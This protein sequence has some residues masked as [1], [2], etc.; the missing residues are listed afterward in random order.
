MNNESKILG[1]LLLIIF[2]FPFS[3][4]ELICPPDH[5]KIDDYYW[6]Y[7]DY[8]DEYE[9]LY[10]FQFNYRLGNIQY[11]DYWSGIIYTPNNF[12]YLSQRETRNDNYEH[13]YNEINQIEVNIGDNIDNEDDENKDKENNDNEDYENEDYDNE[14]SNEEDNN[15]KEYDDEYDEE[16]NDNED[17]ENYYYEKEDSNEENNNNKE[18]EDIITGLVSCD[19]PDYENPELIPIE[20]K[21]IN[22]IDSDESNIPSEP[23]VKIDKE[24]HNHKSLYENACPTINNRILIP[25]DEKILIGNKYVF[26]FNVVNPSDLTIKFKFQAHTIITSFSMMR[27]DK[28]KWKKYED[29]T[30]PLTNLIEIK[31]HSVLKVP[32]EI[33]FNDL[34]QYEGLPFNKGTI[35]SN[36][37]GTSNEKYYHENVLHWRKNLTNYVN[38]SY[39]IYSALEIELESNNQLYISTYS[40]MHK[41]KNKNILNYIGDNSCDSDKSCVEGYGCVSNECIKCEK[42]TCSGCLNN[43]KNCTKCFPISKNGQ[44]NVI[45]TNQNL[46]CDLNFVDITKFDI[47]FN[48]KKQVPPAI[49]FRVT[50]EFWMFVASP[51]LIKGKF[52]NI[53]YKD[54][55]VI[56]L[57]PKT[58][59]NQMNIYCIPLEFIYKFP[60]DPYLIEEVGNNFN[61]FINKTLEAPYLSETI[62]DSA[63]KWFYVRCAYNIES[64][65][66]Y[67]NDQYESNLPIPQYFKNVNNSNISQSNMPFHI[68]KFYKENDMTYL[69][70]D[71]FTNYNDT[72]IYLRNLNIYREYM[73]QNIITKYFNMHEFEYHHMFP[74]L[75]YSMPLDDVREDSININI[76][77]FNTYNYGNRDNT[78]KIEDNV[79]IISNN[80]L[81]ISSNIDNLRPPRTFQ[82]LNLNRLNFQAKD[83]DYKDYQ[84]LY[85]Y[86]NQSYCFEDYKAFACDANTANPK[87]PY[88]LDIFNFTCNEY[89]R[90]GY[91]R[92]LRDTDEIGSQYCSKSC[93]EFVKDCPFEH[94]LYAETNF[95][96]C[97]TGFFDLYYKCYDENDLMNNE[98]NV[99]MYFSG[100]LNSHTIIIPLKHEYTNYAISVWIYPEFRLRNYKY[101]LDNDK[102][103]NRPFFWDDYIDYTIFLTN[104]FRIKLGNY[105]TSCCSYYNNLEYLSGTTLRMSE[106]FNR[107]T[108]NHLTISFDQYASNYEYY[109]TYINHQYNDYMG[110][111]NVTNP[112]KLSTIIF[113]NK[114]NFNYNEYINISD[115][116]KNV[117]WYDAHYR[118][119]QIFDLSTASR[120]SAIFIDK[121]EDRPNSILKHEYFS[122]LSS[123]NRNIVKDLIGN[124]DGFIPIIERSGTFY[125]PDNSNFINYEAYYTAEQAFPDY[126]N[127]YITNVS[128]QYGSIA[129]VTFSPKDEKCIIRSSSKCLKCIKTLSNFNGNCYDYSKKNTKEAYSVYK[130]PGNNMPNKISLNIKPDILKTFPSITVFFFINIYG[131]TEEINL[132]NP[133]SKKIIIFDEATNFYLGY[134]PNINNQSLFIE[135][136][137]RKIFEY[138]NFKKDRF[139]H[140]CPISIAAFRESDRTFQLNMVQASIYLSNLPFIFTY[141]YEMP[142]LEFTELS[143]TNSW[144]GLLR[145]VKIFDDFIMN[146]LGS[147]INPN[148]D[149]TKIPFI[150]IPLRDYYND[151]ANKTDFDS[152]SDEFG[153]KCVK[154]YNP[155]DIECNDPNSLYITY[156]QG[157]AGGC[158]CCGTCG[159]NQFLLHECLGGH[160]YEYDTNSFNDQTC[161]Q[162]HENWINYYPIIDDGHFLR[163][164]EMNNFNLNRLGHI[165]VS[166]ISNIDGNW[167][168]DFWFYT[169]SFRNI[170][171]FLIPVNSLATNDANNIW[172]KNNFKNVIIEWDYHFRIKI[173]SIKLNDNPLN[174]EYK[175]YFTCTPL[176]VKNNPIYDSDESYIVQVNINSYTYQRWFYVNCGASYNEKKFYLTVRSSTLNNEKIFNPKI[177]IDPSKSSSLN[178]DENSPLGYGVTHIREL[179][180]WKCYSCSIAVK[181]TKYKTND[182]SFTNIL[183]RFRGYASRTGSIKNY[184]YSDTLNNANSIKIT[185]KSGYPGFNILDSITSYSECDE[186]DFS[187]AENEHCVNHYNIAR[188]KDFEFILPSSR[189][190]RYTLEFWFFIEQP[191]EMEN[192]LNFYW[193]KHLSISLITD[194]SNINGLIGI[195]FPQAYRDKVDGLKGNEIYDLYEKAINKDRFY[196]TEIANNWAFVRCAVDHTRKLF[197]INENL[198]LTIES[199]ILYGTTKG[200]RPFRYFD[201]SKNSNLKVQNGKINKSRI[202]LR[203]L[204]AFREYLDYKL[205]DT[206]YINFE[207]YKNSW[208]TILYADLNN[209]VNKGCYISSCFNCGY[210]NNCGLP[211]YT[212]EPD[213]SNTP[214][215]NVIGDWLKNNENVFY[216]TYPNI[217]TPIFC[218]AGKVGGINITCSG[219]TCNYCYKDTSHY[220]Y[221]PSGSYHLLDMNTLELTNDCNGNCRLPDVDP[222]TNNGYCLFKPGQNNLLSCGSTY[223]TSKSAEL[224]NNNFICS[225]GYTKVYFECIKDDIIKNSAMYFSNFFSFNNLIYV[226]PGKAEFED[227][228]YGRYTDTSLED[229]RLLSYYLE[230]WFKLD[231]INYHD[232]ISNEEIYLYGYPH[233]IFKDPKDQKFKYSNLKIA[234]GTSYHTLP[235]I[236]EYEWNRIIIENYYYKNNNTFNIKLFTN[237]QF[238]NPD[239]EILN[240]NGSLYKMHFR[241]IVFCNMPYPDCLIKNDPVYLHWGNAWY[242]NIRIWD[243]DITSLQSIQACEIGYTELMNAQKYYWPFTINYINRHEILDLINQ[244]K[245]TLNWWFWKKYYDDDIRENYSTDN[246]DYSL[247][248][249]NHYISKLIN[250]NTE[251]E[252]LPCFSTCKRCYSSSNTDCYECIQGYVLIERKCY[253]NTG[254]YFKTPPINNVNEINILTDIN[255]FHI[256]TQNPLTITIWIKYFGIQLGKTTDTGYFP[257]FYLYNKSTFLAYKPSRQ[258]L[259]F[260]I[261]NEEVEEVEA[262]VIRIKEHIGI[263]T[264]FG[265]SI[266]HSNHLINQFF[267]HMFN[268]MVNR[269][270]ISPIQFQPTNQPVYIN[271]FIF[272]TIPICYYSTLNFYSNFWYG[273]FGH[274]NGISSTRNIDLIYS[275]SLYGADPGTCI[276]DDQLNGITVSSLNPNCIPD[277]IPYDYSYNICQ[278]DKYFIDLSLTSIP[279]C[280]QCD[281]YCNE[282]FNK[283]NDKCSCDFNRGIYW[284]KSND[285]FTKY[286]C[287]KIDSINFAFYEEVTF[288]DLK[289]SNNDEMAIHFWL[290]IYEYKE[291][292]FQSIDIIWSKHIHVKIVDDNNIDP[293]EFTVNCFPYDYI[294]DPSTNPDKLSINFPYR[295]WVYIRC[296]A[297]KYYLKFRLNN[298]EENLNKI[299][300]IQD[301]KSSLTI[302][303][304]NNGNF[305]YGFSFI[306][307]L[308]LFSSY[309]FDFWDDSFIILNGNNFPYLLHYFSFTLEGNDISKIIV[310]DKIEGISQNLILKENRIGYNYIVNYTTF[311]QCNEGN[312]YSQ[313]TSN[314]ESSSG[315]I[316]HINRD[317]NENCLKCLNSQYLNHNDKCVDNCSPNYYGDDYLLQCRPCDPTC[318]TCNGKLNNQCLSCTN[319]YYYIE[320]L[321]ICIENCQVYNLTEE[322]DVPNRC[323]PFKGHGNITNP[324]FLTDYYDYNINNNDYSTKIIDLSNF[325]S[326]TIQLY[327]VTSNLYSHEWI[328]NYEETLKLNENYRLF[329]TEDIL[330]TSPFTSD[331][332][333]NTV[334]IDPSFFKIGYKYYIQI[335]I[336]NEGGVGAADYYLN[337]ILIMNDYPEINSMTSL[338]YT[339]YIITAFLFTCNYCIDDKTNKENL[340]YKFTYVDKR[341]DLFEGYNVNYDI[342]QNEQ[343][344]QDWDT[345]TEV[346]YKF[347]N[348]NPNE[349]ENNN[350]YIKCYCKDEYGL[351]NSTFITIKVYDPPFISGKNIPISEVISTIELNR[352]LSSKQLL[353][354]ADF[355]SILTNY[356]DARTLNRTTITNYDENGETELLNLYD[357]INKEND[358]FCNKRGNSY[359]IYYYL[360]CKCINYYGSNCQID[361]DSY[362]QLVTIYKNLYNKIIKIQTD[363]FNEDILNSIYLLVKSSSEFLQIDDMDY[364][365]NSME[366]IILYFN[367][368]RTE[369]LTETNYKFG[370]D[371]FHYLFEY[372]MNMVNSFKLKNFFEESNS[373]IYNKEELRNKTLN[374]KQINIMKD[375]FKKIK[376]GLERLVYF[377][378]KEKNELIYKS[379]N[380]NIYISKINQNFNFEE[381][382]KDDIN[383][384]QPYFD[385]SD[386]LKHSL[387]S[388]YNAI[389]TAIIYKITPYMTNEEY[390]WNSNSPLITIKLFDFDSI[391]KIYINDCGKGTEA[392]FYFPIS[393]YSIVDLINSKKNNL[394]PEN[395]LST[396]DDVFINLV[397]IDSK[398]K[399]Y[400]TSLDERRNELFVPFNFSCKFYQIENEGKN[401]SLS[402]LTLDYHKYTNNNY[403][404]CYA[405]KFLQSEYS[406]FIVEFYTFDS[407][408]H[409]NSKFFY[410]KYF[411]LITYGPN[412][413]GN[414]AFY[415]FIGIISFYIGMVLL[416]TLLDIKI[417]KHL[418]LL[419]NMKNI[420]IKQNLPYR[421]KY[422]FND[423]IKISPETKNKLDNKRFRDILDGNLDINNIDVNIHADKISVYDKKYKKVNDE[424][425]FKKDYFNPKT[426]KKEIKNSTFFKRNE[427]SEYDLGTDNEKQHTTEKRIENQLQLRNNFFNPNYG[428]ENELNKNITNEI[429]H[430]PN[431]PKNKKNEKIPNPN[432][433]FFDETGIRKNDNK[434]TNFFHDEYDTYNENPKQPKIISEKLKYYGRNN[435]LDQLKDEISSSGDST[436]RNLKNY[437]PSI[438]IKAI[439]N[440]ID[441]NFGSNSKDDLPSLACPL[442]YNKRLLEFFRL[443]ITMME[444]FKYNIK[445]R[446][447]LNITFGKFSIIFHRY[448]RIGNLITQFA[449]YAF[450][451]SIFFTCNVNQTNINKKNH[452]DKLF[453]LYCFITEI[454]S[455]LL[456]HLPAFM[457]YVDVSK[458]RP[459]Y[460]KIIDDEGLNIEKDFNTIINNRCHWNILGVIIQFIFTII[461]FYFSFCFVCIYAYKK[462]TFTY[463]ILITILL[464]LFFFEFIWELILGFLFLIRKRGRGFIYIAEFLNRMRSMKTLT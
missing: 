438:N 90:K 16:N 209:D 434:H 74:Q 382:F 22:V 179:R 19:F 346:L 8:N 186:S 104:S 360:T 458:L 5:F 452:I 347:E 42:Y 417:L 336:I 451:L 164:T 310:E 464:D 208:I 291:H 138:F 47:N 199:E 120:Y 230:I 376:N 258:S 220:F 6:N 359:I 301:I 78:G 118:K 274:I 392:K 148:D 245:F 172:K 428:I 261:H 304:N 72:F 101:D 177:I 289:V 171:N 362:I 124:S 350:Y 459:I 176:I 440:D 93:S 7:Q 426:K 27:N 189:T 307:E 109:S 404:L 32:F 28:I 94:E 212:F 40:M 152:L 219:S 371:I 141:P 203:Q 134:D 326:I 300:I 213:I 277:Y 339:G 214:Y 185:Q 168:M 242:R 319:P 194:K 430:K 454:F 192:G 86:S 173:E 342:D 150:N 453:I 21:L 255:N 377:Y 76:F 181:Y 193:D 89:C 389:F 77:Y 43:K 128:T 105:N 410:L 71:N 462:K 129:Y 137:G 11:D 394:S 58:E 62:E 296:M 294:S 331:I 433:N 443:E 330:S 237:Y 416:Y 159:T 386:C 335:R 280:T 170:Y 361:I 374:E 223:E 119:L 50:M 460:K 276:M 175:Y 253:P 207:K 352:E 211:Y 398:G 265:F 329:K 216:G 251:Y 305:N 68:K 187:Y 370:F 204:R 227:D 163:C 401:I 252:L 44:W 10:G 133:E 400:N 272:S 235:K 224:Y 153:F 81:I 79:K 18:Y 147:I 437:N 249:E 165:N 127:T 281:S 448:Q 2:K 408:F 355:L 107:L 178:I 166:K 37:T 268:F 365:L 393:L 431:P 463:A 14:D 449:L 384:Y 98:E 191:S 409:L 413:K 351:Y 158:S 311:T 439:Y 135:H 457:F 56:S 419:N 264:H 293:A 369:M 114:D 200:Y 239:V 60:D 123:M 248:V 286:Q 395:Q 447:I 340:L 432:L 23:Y 232:I 198:E 117:K 266:Y 260:V 283:G 140:W 188:I 343:V 205:F 385:L 421:E 270:I 146:A 368:F 267:P 445:N 3:N 288:T 323:G 247:L 217:Y 308:R 108:W 418:K 228:E 215:Y 99:G 38:Y 297:D 155:F 195:C 345:K 312:I 183:H 197:Y 420:I 66:W 338:P 201:Y 84:S 75:L 236:D 461:S 397:Y 240:L 103:L 25:M 91:M 149:S 341:D 157:E 45:E 131:F 13:C 9:Y 30:F 315:T 380:L 366:Y 218:E 238:S 399:V 383:K 388:N 284:I 455:C 132:D 412:Y 316:C 313:I 85:R 396:K 182:F 156:Y 442:T 130:N 82:R 61:D 210:E 254:Y 226:T 4:L 41:R 144:V 112:P 354:I 48:I 92:A 357:P 162:K 334:N 302:V 407:N 446:Y 406:E 73:P 83:C 403:I 116:C 222:N 263:W 320:E 375:Y 126:L 444:F 378:V 435:F 259:I 65:K 349:N 54:F 285:N 111:I 221:V 151:C 169:Q 139:G 363:Q 110:R 332:T 20:P 1:L 411:Q 145:D 279:P 273:T 51:Q 402:N 55:M 122:T 142:Y 174:N 317:E 95:F 333:Q 321:H 231:K 429:I 425:K 318:Y 143:I 424:I 63:S 423:D 88:Y 379:R 348:I 31:P 184:T 24:Y 275:V 39:P 414:N 225:P 33:T 256:S 113:C 136:N 250:N 34:S 337:Y 115:Y 257:L 196:F 97:K 372:G 405:N 391:K 57:L 100:F 381:Y 456:I 292:K 36:I 106:M 125:N 295:K 154:D 229:P 167:N 70:F 26:Y 328:Y 314:C 290:M 353:N 367:S 29:K 344:I 387:M 17:Y 306:R 269:N 325:I 243:A 358:L 53:I 262:Y 202:F 303:D 67:L 52:A 160:Y 12:C 422:Y 299:P 241:G 102:K 121:W 415:Y 59:A 190:N 450:F 87:L 364:L 427:S 287:E 441:L 233:K 49:H 436:K 282:C 271:Q 298:L 324:I 161:S 206:R 96:R 278:N 64:S 234:S 356:E 309:N 15:N 373:E 327:N 322:K 180:L 46:T 80:K 244:Y 69:Q 390:Y 35:T 246:F